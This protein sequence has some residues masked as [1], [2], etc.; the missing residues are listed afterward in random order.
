MSQ[1]SAARFA[2]PSAASSVPRAWQLDQVTLMAGYLVLLFVIPSR[3]TVGVLGGAGSPALILGAGLGLLW[4]FDRLNLGRRARLKGGHPVRSGL[5][6]VAI[7]ILVTYVLAMS[8]PLELGE[9]RTADLGLV[10]L[11]SW[12]GVLLFTHDCIPSR[13]RLLT[14]ARYVCVGGACVA[15]FGLVQFGTGKE[16]VNL[17]HIPG[18]S[19]NSGFT[20]LGIREGFNRPSGTALHPIEFGAVITMILPVALALALSD[21]RR[22]VVRR[23][24]PPLL[25]APAVMVS[26][27]RSAIVGAVVGCLVLAAALPWRT[28]VKLAATSAVLAVLAFL[29]IPG[30]LGT[31][32]GLFTTASN[33]PSV[34]SRTG[35]YTVAWEFLENHLLMGRGFGTF[36]PRYRIFDN[37][38]LLS[39]VE[40]GVLGLLAILVLFGCAYAAARRV[41]RQ[42]TDPTM[43]LLGQ[44]LAAAVCVG[45]TGLAIYDGFSFPMGTGTMF[46]LIGMTGAAY[47]LVRSH[48]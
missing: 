43:A 34:Q 45:G 14:L 37:Q 6:V 36:Q 28:V 5:A 3:L 31:V 44:G 1:V 16:W 11:V 39:L 29:T 35:S 24:T 30:L 22:S 10:T 19:E 25:I 21:T 12:S 47:R 18:L 32:L 17:L 4:A 2:V 27:S 9:S 20:A 33:D 48:G 41:C 15:A 40:L 46:L 8:R 13:E 7:C 42:A 23:W 38:Y 26:V